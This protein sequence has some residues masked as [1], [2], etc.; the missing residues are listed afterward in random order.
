MN[1]CRELF[2]QVNQVLLLLLLLLLDLTRQEWLL[3]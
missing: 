2:D 1:Q 3:E